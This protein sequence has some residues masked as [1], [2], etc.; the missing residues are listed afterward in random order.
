MLHLQK[1]P[2]ILSPAGSPDSLY[3]AL[4][5]GAD[6]VYFGLSAHNARQNAKNFTPEDTEKALKECR[7][8]GVKSNI[9]LNT[10]VTDREIPEA[11][12]LAYDAL[13][14]G[15]DAFIVQDLGLA[16]ALKK[17][18]PGIVLHASTQCACHSRAGAEQLAELGF[19]RIVLAAPRR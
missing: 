13:C 8:R 2:L 5:A 15:A 4:D 7:L 14:M 17:S 6:E 1:R 18:I 16:V 9:T 12:R 11:C 3:A 19:E 10:L